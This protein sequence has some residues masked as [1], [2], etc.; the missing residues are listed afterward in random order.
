MKDINFFVTLFCLTH[1]NTVI[2]QQLN[3]NIN[4][5][6]CALIYYFILYTEQLY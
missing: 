5:L 1:S 2:L 4:K 6:Q 3:V